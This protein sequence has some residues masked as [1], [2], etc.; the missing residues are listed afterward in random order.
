MGRGKERPKK[1]EKKEQMIGGRVVRAG[2]KMRAMG[3]S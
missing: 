1:L 2:D 3:E